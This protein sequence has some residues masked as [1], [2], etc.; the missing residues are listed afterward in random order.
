MDCKKESCKLENKGYDWKEEFAKVMFATNATQED[1]KNALKLKEQNIPPYLYKYRGIG[2]FSIKNFRN[3]EL[4]FNAASKM[5]DPYDSSLTVDIDYLVQRVYEKEGLEEFLQEQIDDLKKH[6]LSSV[7]LKN[8]EKEI[9]NAAAMGQATVNKTFKEELSKLS[10][11]LQQLTYISCFSE[12][13]DSILMWSHYTNNHEGFCLEYDFM[14]PANRSVQPNIIEALSPIIYDHKILDMSDHLFDFYVENAKL[15]KRLVSN[16]AVRKSKEWEYEQ[17]W[18]V[19]QFPDNVEEGF[20]MAFFKPKAIYLGARISDQNKENLML[21]A[22]YKKVNVY[23]MKL[24][25]DEFK[26]VAHPE[27]IFS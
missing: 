18:R 14:D 1:I 8:F 26:L 27:L 24:K 3:D 6:N 20:E 21:L 11:T 10:P 22:E 16:A 2:K 12:K 25:D 4:W 13:N 19:I 17:E 23:Q 5:N 9:R 15:D 7:D